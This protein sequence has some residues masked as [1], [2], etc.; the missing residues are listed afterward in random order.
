MNSKNISRLAII[1]ARGGSVRIKNK[2][3]K[4]FCG[5]PI[6]S[7]PINSAKKSHLFKK[8]H[9]STDSLRISRIV[10]NSNLK[11]DFLRPKL[12]ANNSA[13]L[14]KVCKFVFE[15][16]LSL[17]EVYDE[18]WCI[19]P[20]TPLI[21]EHDLLSASKFLNKN[22]LKKPLMTISKFRTPIEWALTKLNNKKIKPLNYKSLLIRSQDLKTKYYDAGLFYVFTPNCFKKFNETTITTK[23]FG[24]EISINKAVDIDTM[25]DWN[26]AEL[27]YKGMKLIKN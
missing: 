26:F 17:G 18:I 20:C 22:K 24:F 2:N 27:I 1:P 4:L 3:I 10:K 19:L 15:K 25:E 13:G 5:K 23:F 21:N 11:I 6:I 14:F 16:Y 7:Y 12:L 9:I 8:I